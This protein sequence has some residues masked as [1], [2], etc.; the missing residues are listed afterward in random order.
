MEGP[1]GTIESEAR[2]KTRRKRRRRAGLWWR[3]E[4]ER[5]LKLINMTKQ[6]SHFE[7]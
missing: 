1:Y 3:E 5:S 7:G 6:V 2:G 4:K